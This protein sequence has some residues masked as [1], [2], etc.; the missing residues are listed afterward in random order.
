LYEITSWKVRVRLNRL[1]LLVQRHLAAMVGQRVDH[2]R[3]VLSRLDDFIEVADGPGARRHGQRAVL[4][5]RAAGIQQVAAHQVAGRHVLVAGHGDQRAAQLPGHVFDEARLAA[6]G[7]PLDHHRQPRGIGRF[8][9]RHFVALLLVERCS[10]GGVQSSHDGLTIGVV[11]Q[12][13]EAG[14]QSVLRR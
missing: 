5:A 7:R 6:A 9:Q 14:R 1:A 10:A 2:H 11:Q 12:G 8:V 3:G 4:P 13:Q